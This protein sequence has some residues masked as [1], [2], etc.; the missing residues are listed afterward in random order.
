MNLV[1]LLRDQNHC[2]PAQSQLTFPG[3]FFTINSGTVKMN[4]TG[5]VNQTKGSCHMMQSTVTGAGR[6]AWQAAGLY[7][8]QPIVDD[9]P[10]RVKAYVQGHLSDIWIIVGYGPSSP[11]SQDTLTKVIP[12]PISKYGSSSHD[13]LA[14]KFDDIILLPGLIPSDTDYQ[15]PIAFA[16]AM[17][18]DAALQTEGSFHLSVQNLSKTAPQFAASMS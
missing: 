8:T 15:K 6:N 18:T 1:N 5:V 4:S 3:N 14:G 13:P 7:M 2:N 17:A 10:Y 9:T 11:T 16:V 12:F